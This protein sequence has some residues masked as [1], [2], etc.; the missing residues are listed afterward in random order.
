[1]PK[2]HARLRGLMMQ[3]DYDQHQLARKLGIG[4]TNMNQK[5]NYH[6]P[7][8]IEEAYTILDLFGVPTEQLHE[9][10]PRAVTVRKRGA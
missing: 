9:V 6:T 10:F 4:I 1:M 8:T 5:I 3:N 7:F 2:T